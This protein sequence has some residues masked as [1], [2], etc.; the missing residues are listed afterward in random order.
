MIE[1]K[2]I[3][4]FEGNRSDPRTTRQ[5]E[6]PIC[7]ESRARSVLVF[8]DFQYF[9]DSATTPK[10]VDVTDVMC[11]AC[12]AVYLNPVFTPFGFQCFF[13]EA[14]QSYGATAGRAA[15]QRKWL[16][17]RGL[18][19]DGST[20]LDVGCYDGDFLS[21]LPET[22][23]R[24]GVDIDEPAI[25]RGRE[26]FG[27]RGVEFIL[28][29]FDHFQMT[30]KPDAIVL[31]HVLEHLPEPVTTLANLRRH[32][33]SQTR[34]VVEVPIVEHGLTNDVNGFLSAQHLTHFSRASLRNAMA[35]AGWEIIEVF[36]QPD[37]NGCRVLAKPSEPSAKVKP[38][39]SDAEAY[40]QYLAH[41]KG[42]VAEVSGRL[43][44]VP[45][46]G[47]VAIWGAGLHTE[48]LYQVSGLFKAPARRF[49]LFDGDRIKAGK[50]WRGIGI[51]PSSRL[52]DVDWS[53]ADR[54][55]ISSYGSQPDMTRLAAQ[56]GV[57]S[58]CVVT[59]YDHF[60]VY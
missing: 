23:N 47:R 44:A 40:R 35:K 36:Q 9:T 28:G 46:S 34:L 43:E 30:K 1:W 19:A 48:F 39:P 22:M 60:F 21:Q 29:D 26:R 42:V 4:S 45:A 12:S 25:A 54:L 49:A 38:S 13:A 6:C 52:S 3:D 10:R 55:V 57:P 14:G 58:E 59:L 11:D 53:P 32:S 27:M 17:E 24:V 18:L 7:G 51:S 56:M 2:T 33:H 41:W 31:F 16:G 37:Y 8:P 5:R 50:S 15:E 20:L